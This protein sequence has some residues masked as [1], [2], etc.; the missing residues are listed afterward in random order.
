MPPPH[1]DPCQM[2]PVVF[3]E[4]VAADAQSPYIP[5]FLTLG[6]MYIVWVSVCWLAA[7]A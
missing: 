6:S 1:L 5:C 2:S 4:E 7:R 3:L